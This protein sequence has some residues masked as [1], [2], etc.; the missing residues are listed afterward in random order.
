ME[1]LRIHGIGDVEYSLL[2]LGVSS[3]GRQDEVLRADLNN[4]EH[5]TTIQITTIIHACQCLR[6]SSLVLFL[7]IS[8]T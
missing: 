2:V 8:S 1:R 7:A 4:T 5:E 6:D 3:S